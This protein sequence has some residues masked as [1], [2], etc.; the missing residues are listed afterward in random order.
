MTTEMRWAIFF[1][2]DIFIT[3]GLGESSEILSPLDKIGGCFRDELF[4]VF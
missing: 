3:D 4:W 2:D 1:L